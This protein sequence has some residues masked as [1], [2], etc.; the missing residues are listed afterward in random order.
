MKVC[1]GTSQNQW[2]NTPKARASP[3]STGTCSGVNPVMICAVLLVG[4][5][6]THLGGEGA[7]VVGDEAVHGRRLTGLRGVPRGGDVLAQLEAVLFAQD[8]VELGVGVGVLLARVGVG[9]VHVG[10]HRVGH[11]LALG[12][13]LGPLGDRVRQVLADHSLEGLAVLRVRRGGR[14]RCPASGS[15]TGPPRR[16]PWR[17]CDL[18][19]SCAFLSEPLS[20][21]SDVCLFGLDS[22]LAHLVTSAVGRH[23]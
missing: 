20:G 17:G 11:H 14:A 9:A 19:A 7:D 6:A 12:T 13:V 15:R 5:L 21:H 8:V 3:L 2:S 1:E 16:G 10:G 4:G 23:S 22:Q 18:R